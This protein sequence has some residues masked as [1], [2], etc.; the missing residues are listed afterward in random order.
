MRNDGLVETIRQ[1]LV[2]HDHAL[3]G[4]LGPRRI[5][6]A[7][8]TA[9]G[10]S[11]SFIEDYIR[12]SVLPYY[13][14]T[15]TETS[16]TGHQTTRF[17]EDARNIIL[18][19]VHGDERDA[20]LFCGSGATGTVDRLINILNLRLPNELDERYGLAEKIPTDQRPVI[21]IGPYEHHSNEV[22]W[23]ETIADV[24]VIEE[25]AEG[26][27]DLDR[28]AASLIEYQDRPL[29]IG[30]FSAASNVTGILSNTDD[31][32]ALL[33]RHGAIAAWDFA[34]AAPY[35]PIHMNR[36]GDAGGALSKDV[37][38][39]SPHKFPG[40]P[41]TPGVLLIKRALLKNRVPV[42]PGGGTVS[43]VSAD[44]HRYIDDP[45]HREEGGTPD[46]VGAIR[47]GLIFQLKEAVGVEEI[48]AHEKMLARRAVK[49]LAANPNIEIL[50]NEET[51]RLPILSFLVRHG[52]RHLHH[53]FVVA[54]LNDFFGLQTRGDCS[55]AGPYGHRLLGIDSDMSKAF[56]GHILAGCEIVKP[57]WTR[58]GL[59]YFNS[60]D[61]VDFIL[62][63]IDWLA[64]EGW[65]LLPA[66]RCDGATGRWWHADMTTP[67]SQTLHDVHFDAQGIVATA[68]TD[69]APRHLIGDLIAAANQAIEALQRADAAPP[70]CRGVMPLEAAHLQWFPLPDDTARPV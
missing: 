14:N 48:F 35:V 67:N 63:A 52:Q 18:Q 21:F 23:R 62:G 6:Y 2:G 68:P 47:A 53:D 45:V 51:E 43:Y 49:R 57:G 16:G 39:I 65:K 24:I 66:Y 32:T 15:H 25:N 46:I 50:G 19:A 58:F 60:D 56:E 20:V 33:H 69:P 26:L 9:S 22:L 5:V 61:E 29:K 4:P 44:E 12:Q 41:G 1:S 36:A 17:R 37:I 11:L 31:V 64:S 10:R 8:Y 27:V 54:V 28:L 40:G 3:P 30:S 59:N 42:V 13:A 55:C 70:D 34:A 7:D 38:F